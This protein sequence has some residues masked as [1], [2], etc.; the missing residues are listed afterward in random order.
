MWTDGRTADRRVSWTATC[1]N[2]FTPIFPKFVSYGSRKGR[3]PGFQFPAR[4]VLKTRV[5]KSV[6]FRP[7]F[8]VPGN[9]Q[10]GY[11]VPYQPSSVTHH[12]IQYISSS[13]MSVDCCQH[14]S[15]SLLHSS[16]FMFLCALHAGHVSLYDLCS[17]GVCLL[18]DYG[19]SRTCP[20]CTVSLLSYR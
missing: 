1:R 8:L 11:W 16:L 5:E 20:Y 15:C 3:F 12:P 9:C 13:G 7:R 6:F 18:Q 10:N 19:I 17:K 4:L 2:K 14:L